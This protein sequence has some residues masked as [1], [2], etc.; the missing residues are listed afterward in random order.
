MTDH[1][2]DVNK[3]VD[4]SSALSRE[5]VEKLAECFPVDILNRYKKALLA[6]DA[7]LRATITQRDEQIEKLAAFI[8]AQ[9]PG[10][11]SKSE[12][13]VDTAIRIITQ[14][15]QELERVKEERDA[16][17]V[18]YTAAKQ[19]QRDVEKGEF[20]YWNDDGQDHLDSL[21][22]PVVVQPEKVKEWKQQLAAS[23]ARCR[24]METQRDELNKVCNYHE[25]LEADM[26]EKYA[27]LQATLA[28]RE[29]RIVTLETAL[30]G[31]E[32]VRLRERVSS[33]A[34]ELYSTQQ[35]AGR[36]KEAAA[37]LTCEVCK[38]DMQRAL[39]GA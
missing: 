39:K 22:C 5:Q 23:Q 11:P 28:A 15:A 30:F 19:I 34:A 25:K 8:I 4:T 14:Q 29:E 12:G 6:H 31:D 33:L 36:L 27:Q 10:E 13:A 1:I 24:E 37:S 21:I 35:E 18:K 20:W 26:L 2:V 38:M 3:K 7:T 16:W 17:Q 9:V 32:V